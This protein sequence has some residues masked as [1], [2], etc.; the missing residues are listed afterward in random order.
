LRCV[1]TACPRGG[2]AARRS[3]VAARRS[4]AR[5]V[6]ARAALHSSARLR[7][8]PL[9]LLPMWARLTRHPSTAAF[10]GM[11]ELPHPDIKHPVD[12]DVRVAACALVAG[13]GRKGWRWLV[14]LAVPRGPPLAAPPKPARPCLRPHCTQPRTPPP[15]PAS[16]P[17]L[18]PP[19]ARPMI[20]GLW[21]PVSPPFTLPHPTHLHGRHTW[22]SC[23]GARP[24]PCTTPWAPAAWGTRAAGTQWW[25]PGS[26]QQSLTRHISH[27]HHHPRRTVLPSVG[28]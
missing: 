27:D 23:A 28:S 15:P 20:V 10:E 6:Q 16:P 4:A 5:Y 9:F 13:G 18:C 24:S 2:V 12:S 14:H 19:R 8:V 25:T 21:C 7:A 3:G 26:S 22:R 17:R 1:C 11:E